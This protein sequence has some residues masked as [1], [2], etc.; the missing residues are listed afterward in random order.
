MN[1]TIDAEMVR[2]V[3][4]QR[5]LTPL[6]LS[7]HG[8]MSLATVYRL[9]NAAPHRVTAATAGRLAALLDVPVDLITIKPGT[10]DG[11]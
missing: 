10:Q 7:R 4:A 5:N 8:T 9:L 6:G 3:M 11:A 1:L 2:T